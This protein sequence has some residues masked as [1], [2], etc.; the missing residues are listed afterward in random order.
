MK[1]ILMTL[2]MAVV[3]MTAQAEDYAY[4]TFETTDG[5]KASVA[6]SSLSLSISGT[7]LTAGTKS[8]NLTNL[9]KMYFST[10]DETTTGTQ[11]IYEMNAYDLMSATE[12]YDLRGHRITRS[13]VTRGA[14][15]I[16][17]RQGTYKIIVR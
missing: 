5:T 7:T 1:K 12:I 11:E 14:Y 16:K 4:L 15:I 9:S 17:N 2:L 6:A 10:S 13:Q 3:A 8:F